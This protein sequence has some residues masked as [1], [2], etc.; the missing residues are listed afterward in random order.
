MFHREM[1]D[2]IEERKNEGTADAYGIVPVVGVS[3]KTL[4]SG[5]LN[6]GQLMISSEIPEWI[7]PLLSD[8]DGTVP[9]FSAIPIEM[10]NKY[11]ESFISGRHGSLQNNAQ[12]LEDIYQRLKQM[13]VEGLDA[14]RGPEI[15]HKAEER[16]TLALEI[17]DMYLPEEQVIIRAKVYNANENFGGIIAQI[18]SID[19]VGIPTM[20]EMV[21]TPD[22]WVLQLHDQPAGLYRIKVQVRNFSPFS[23]T[24]IEDIF[25]IAR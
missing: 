22:S 5:F 24:P 14:I 12:V 7:D 16:A 9:R 19:P 10:S 2:A 11:L 8:G 17:D 23:P 13:E 21:E 20:F 25:E 6:A 1:E 4:Q 15:D 3:Q 18:E